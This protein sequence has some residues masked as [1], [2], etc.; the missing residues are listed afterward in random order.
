MIESML[1]AWSLA[2]LLPRVYTLLAS[3]LGEITVVGFLA[4]KDAPSTERPSDV[5]AAAFEVVQVP[6]PPVLA[7]VSR[8]VQDRSDVLTIIA[9]IIALVAMARSVSYLARN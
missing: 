9:G 7:S 3:I 2:S 1:S 5:V 4:V 8:W 6:A